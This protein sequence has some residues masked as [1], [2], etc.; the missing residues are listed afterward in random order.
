M[1]AEALVQKQ[2]R[3]MVFWRLVGDVIGFPRRILQ[4]LL[5][6]I[7]EIEQAA[8]YLEL[9][10][11]RQYEALTGTDLGCASGQDGRYAGL[12]PEPVYDLE[13]DE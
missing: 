13:D 5:D 3:R 11:A 7:A 6:G 12:H 2:L 4:G 9:D 8:F 1:S 10:A